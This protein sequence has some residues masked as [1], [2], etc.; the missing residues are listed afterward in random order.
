[1]CES[2]STR[3]VTATV[4][5]L[6]VS[7]SGCGE[8]LAKARTDVETALESWKKAEDPKVLGSQGIEFVDPDRQAGHRLLDYTTKTV[9]S[10]PQQGPRVV[11]VL[12]L[13]TKAGKKIQSEVAY[14]V[15]PGQTTK[16]GRDAFHVAGQ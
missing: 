10:Q 3:I 8:N 12:N 1:M 9:A 15:I 7:L 11:V 4:F 6:V 13:Q 14:E 16:I 5:L 2:F